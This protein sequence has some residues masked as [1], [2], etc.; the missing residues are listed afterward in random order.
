VDPARRRRR[1]AK[2]SNWLVTN[3][4]RW[5]RA[6]SRLH[7]RLYKLTGG[8]FLPRWFDGAPVMVLETVGRRSGRPR[9]NPILYLRHGEKL[10]VMAS[11]AGN[12]RTPQW[13]LNLLAAGEGTV[14]IGGE[15]TP[16]RVTRV[17]EGAERERV[18]PRFAEMY[19]QADDY[20]DFTDREIQLVE[21]EPA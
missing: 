10:V 21:L 6:W 3:R 7:G 2:R 19:P 8:R 14:V 13:C 5:Q 18:W 1:I 9:A 17:L 12:D 4:P 16:V 20:T 15:R 11:N